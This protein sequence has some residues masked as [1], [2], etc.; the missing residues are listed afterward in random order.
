MNITAEILTKQFV[1]V[2]SGQ[3]KTLKNL[4]WKLFT[5]KILLLTK[6][7]LKCYKKLYF[8]LMV[9]I[10]KGKMTLHSFLRFLFLILNTNSLYQ[11]VWNFTRNGVSLMCFL[12]YLIGFWYFTM[13]SFFDLE[14]VWTKT[15]HF[16]IGFLFHP[17]EGISISQ[18]LPDN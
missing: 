2:I 6:S 4:H 1:Q 16:S 12:K 7:S 18:K 8:R 9:T 5:I 11:I 10:F 15:L 14:K 17:C 3:W 13:F